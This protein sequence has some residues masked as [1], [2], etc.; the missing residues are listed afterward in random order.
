MQENPVVKE[1][2]TSPGKPS[3]WQSIEPPLS[4]KADDNGGE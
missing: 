1:A 3:G 4:I 2:S